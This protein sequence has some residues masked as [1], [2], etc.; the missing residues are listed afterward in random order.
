VAGRADIPIE[1]TAVAVNTTAVDPAGP[2]FV[3]VYP[4]GSPRPNASNLN[5]T[6]GQTIPNAVVAKVGTDGKVCL[7]TSGATHLVVDVDG[8]FP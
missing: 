1:A 7:F 8:Y 2:G 6:A 3:T 5:F 4:C